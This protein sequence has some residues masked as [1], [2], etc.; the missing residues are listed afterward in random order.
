MPI[1][2]IDTGRYSRP[3]MSAIWEEENKLDLM[4]K[5]EASLARAHAEVGN[6]SASAA[7]EIVTKSSIEHVSL[8]RVKEI[9]D[10]IHHDVMAMVIAI[11]EVCEGD[12]GRYVH[13]GATS[14]DITDTALSLQLRDS[15]ALLK[16]KT[17]EIRDILLDHAREKRDLVCI[18]RTHGQHALPTTYGLKFA[19]WACEMQR[20]LDRLCEADKRVSVGKMT[21]AVGTQSALGPKG[22]EIQRLVME[23]LG[24]GVPLV[25]SQ[26]LQRDRHSDYVFCLVQLATTFDKIFTE[27][28]NLQRSEI[29]EVREGF[30]KKQVGSSTMP[31]KRNPMRSERICGLA[32]VVRAMLEPQLLCN[33]LWHERDLTNSSCE[34]VILP[35]GTMYLYYAL[36]LGAEVLSGLEFELENIDRNLDITKGLIMAER[37]MIVLTEKGLGRQDAHALVREASML[38]ISEDRN[39]KDVILSDG[40]FTDLL[41]PEEIES[42]MNPRTY[43]G[44][45]GEQVDGVMDIARR[46]WGYAN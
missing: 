20:N 29:N 25:T 34:R 15:I 11:T 43:L 6:I 39:F 3:E 33:V 44:T 35:E 21:G 12:S 7:D 18:G 4:L 19:L 41:S 27:I 17:A 31:A 2:P 23:D 13:L 22:L 26:V 10:E 45:A 1:T 8:D 16:K 46:E 24:L 9:E 14:N 36:C 37:L 28:R 40:R 5:V 42:T 38:A 30:R 32:R